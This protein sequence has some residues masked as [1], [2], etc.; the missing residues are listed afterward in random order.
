MWVTSF[1]CTKGETADYVWLYLY[2]GQQ[3]FGPVVQAMP[4]RWLRYPLDAYPA[5]RERARAEKLGCKVNEYAEHGQIVLEA[6]AAQEIL[7]GS[8][9]TRVSPTDHVRWTLKWP[10]QSVVLPAGLEDALVEQT[11]VND[12]LREVLYLPEH[13]TLLRQGSMGDAAHALLKGISQANLN[14]S[15]IVN[16]IC[17]GTSAID[18]Q[19]ARCAV[20]LPDSIQLLGP[21]K[22]I[23]G[24][25]ELMAAGDSEVTD[26]KAPQGMQPNPRM[27]LFCYV[28]PA[29]AKL[30][31]TLPCPKTVEYEGTIAECVQCSSDFELRRAV[32]DCQRKS[33]CLVNSGH[34]FIDYDAAHL[35]NPKRDLKRGVLRGGDGAFRPGIDNSQPRYLAKL[36]Q[37][38]GQRFQDSSSNY[39]DTMYAMLSYFFG[40]VAPDFTL[41]T[42]SEL[43][44][45]VEQRADYKYQKDMTYDEI[46]ELMDVIEKDPSSYEE[47]IL[48]ILKYGLGD[49]VKQRPLAEALIPPTQSIAS[50]LGVE[51]QRACVASPSTLVHDYLERQAYAHHALLSARDREIVLHKRVPGQKWTLKQHRE[52]TMRDYITPQ[53]GFFPELELLYVPYYP[54]STKMT[55]PVQQLV[56][57]AKDAKPLAA[58]MHLMVA[59]SFAVKPLA[60]AHD[61]M[62]DAAAFTSLYGMRK[63]ELVELFSESARAQLQPLEAVNSNGKMV[64]VLPGSEKPPVHVSFGKVP[65]LS[66]K[67]G[68]MIYKLGSMICSTGVKIPSKK[69]RYGTDHTFDIKQDIR[70]TYDSLDTLF[71]EG[72][73]AAIENIRQGLESLV[74]RQLPLDAYARAYHGN[75][76]LYSSKA[77]NTL[78]AAVKEYFAVQAGETVLFCRELRN[79]VSQEARYTKG[80]DFIP[81]VAY[82]FDE[83]F[84]P[85]KRL[86]KIVQALRDNSAARRMRQE[87]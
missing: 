32:A 23:P 34:N 31:T 15:D 66:L 46:E 17:N 4:K 9:W 65:V 1:R 81:D 64:V 87:L 84:R 58:M 83:I 54:I 72:R 38:F 36:G 10:H 7:L 8:A 40:N 62:L 67:P 22:D 73:A 26:Y 56:Q 19:K 24:T 75:N 86:Y 27:F 48:R 47:E 2:D 41:P 13:R 37:S 60:D 59:D 85:G 49:T 55:E 18:W 6:L 33:G 12:L 52:K 82:Y 76:R 71:R 20:H 77:Q 51:F 29:G 50:I 14:L 63:D 68:Q 25:L 16:Q 5:A 3:Q 39:F 28:S 57:A 69:K 35:M 70:L 44:S 53:K 30:F 79:G 61:V 11:R 43:V 78:R 74:R 42:T 80:A 45:V 21:Y